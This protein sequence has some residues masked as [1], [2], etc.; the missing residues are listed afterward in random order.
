MV[1]GALGAKRPPTYLDVDAAALEMGR[2][3]AAGTGRRHPLVGCGTVDAS[4]SVAIVDPETGM[5]RGPGEVGEIWVRGPSV[6]AGYWG[7]EETTRARFGAR[8]V[9]GAPLASGP[10]EE[11]LRT[12]DLGFLHE[13]ELFITGRLQDLLILRGRNVYPQDLE[14]LAQAAHTRV[15]PSCVAAFGLEL[16]GEER[17]VLVAEV[18]KRG[19]GFSSDEVM[20]A[21][22]IEGRR[23][24]RSRAARGRVGAARVDPQDHQRQGPAAR[25]QA[26]VAGR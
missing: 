10:H 11:H 18:D 22:S 21:D 1:S 2:V 6:A 13:G 15:R 7:D 16:D 19:E 9:S 5:R 4:L 24:S 23:W 8:L 14:E 20:A 12:G 26:N 3:T 17:A 25:D